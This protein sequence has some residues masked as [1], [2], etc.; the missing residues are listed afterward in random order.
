MT[1]RLEVPPPQ[2]AHL[3]GWGR[4]DAHVAATEPIG[5]ANTLPWKVPASMSLVYIYQ[6]QPHF[7]KP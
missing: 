7:W 6:K 5:V 1:Q 4:A 3:G 2:A